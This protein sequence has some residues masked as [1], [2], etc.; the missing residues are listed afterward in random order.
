MVVHGYDL[1]LYHDING[2]D[3]PN[4][5]DGDVAMFIMV[6]VEINWW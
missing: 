6:M 5:D 3:N 4:C 2:G 1:W